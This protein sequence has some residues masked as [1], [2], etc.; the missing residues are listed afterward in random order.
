MKMKNKIIITI[1]SCTLMIWASGGLSESV[2]PFNKYSTGATGVNQFTGTG[3]YTFS[4]IKGPGLQYSSNVYVNA[5]GH[6]SIAPTGWVALGWRLG[7]GC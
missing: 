5:H 7:T 1:L 3:Q 6:N 2:N 4:F